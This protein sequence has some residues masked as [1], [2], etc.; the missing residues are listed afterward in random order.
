MNGIADRLARLGTAALA[1]A[2]AVWLGPG[3]RGLWTGA[4][5]AAPA[6]TVRARPGDNRPLHHAVAE[7]PPGAVLALSVAGRLEIAIFGD[8]L[9]R[10]GTARGVAGLVTDGAVR[11]SDGIRALGF[12][13]F[14]GG[15]SL[16]KPEKTDPGVF[17][18]HVRIGLAEV[19]PSDWL[20]GD[21]DGVV[22]VAGRRLEQLTAAAEVVEQRERDLVDR[23][24]AG[25]PTPDQLGLG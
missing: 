24:A 23:A 10:I 18:E 16:R 12:P 7:A 8:V 1:D 21:G 17:G 4:R 25:E 19:G 15:I 6:Y 3:V 20:V 14:C 5:I 2:G 13:V 9:A 11:D 22:V